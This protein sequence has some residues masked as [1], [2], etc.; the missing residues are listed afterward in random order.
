MRCYKI[1]EKT[2]DLVGFKLCDQDR[3]ILL[4]TTE[5]I[6]IRMSLENISIIGR[7]ASGVKLMNLDKDGDTTIASVAK[8]RESDTEE[9]SE[10]SIHEN[11]EEGTEENTENS[12]EEI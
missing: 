5:G 1:T 12:I 3:E 4:I 8:V 9:E 6:M 7:N 11:A 10:D 2:G